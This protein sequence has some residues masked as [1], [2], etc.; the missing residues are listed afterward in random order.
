VLEVLR[1]CALQ[2]EMTALTG[3]CY[4]MQAL[5]D[6]D[7][8]QGALHVSDGWLLLYIQSLGE[9]LDYLPFDA[10]F[11]MRMVRVHERR[12]YRACVACCGI[13]IAAVRLEQLGYC[14]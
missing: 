1:W 10:E 7:Q 11:H 4:R 14:F 13:Q 8:A 12:T 9:G 5:D 6:A 2:G 3:V